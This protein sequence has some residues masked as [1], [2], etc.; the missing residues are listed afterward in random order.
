MT[1]FNEMLP[2]YETK[3]T[4]SV[5]TARSYQLN[6][7]NAKL[8][9]KFGI[10]SSQETCPA[11]QNNPQSEGYSP[12]TYSRPYIKSKDWRNYLSLVNRVTTSQA[13]RPIARDDITKSLQDANSEGPGNSFINQPGTVDDSIHLCDPTMTITNIIPSQR[14]SLYVPHQRIGGE[15]SLANL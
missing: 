14:A 11:T 2:F 10:H 4:Y 15:E 13:V 3:I 12:S 9:L 6:W 8:I 7:K 5:I 1:C